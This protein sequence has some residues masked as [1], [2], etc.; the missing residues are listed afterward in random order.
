[1]IL[2]A[3]ALG[4]IMGALG[5]KAGQYMCCNDRHKEPMYTG[6]RKKSKISKR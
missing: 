1:M 2:M 4:G 5:M 3:M 6:R